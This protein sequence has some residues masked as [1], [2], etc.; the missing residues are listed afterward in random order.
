MTHTKV[1]MNSMTPFE[2]FINDVTNDA[3][4]VA[5]EN[6]SGKITIPELDKII[7]AHPY[8]ETVNMDIIEDAVIEIENILLKD[9]RLSAF[10]SDLGADHRSANQ[11]LIDTMHAM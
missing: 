9:N 2:A 10:G 4:L 6:E 8:Y 3:F 5:V 1:L 7:Y 11:Q